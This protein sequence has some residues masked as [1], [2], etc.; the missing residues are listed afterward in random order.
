M[1]AVWKIIALHHVETKS[2]IA[3]AGYLSDMELSLMNAENAEK[4]T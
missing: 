3:Y 2:A 4:T 1:E